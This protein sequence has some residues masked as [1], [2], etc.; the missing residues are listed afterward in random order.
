MR[1][2]DWTIIDTL[3]RY[4]SITKA[5]EIL[6][7]SQ[8]TLT[9]RIQAIE[10]DLGVTL[11][12]RS[13]RGIVFTQAGEY[14]AVQAKKIMELVNET[15]EQFSA[16]APV[17]EKLRICAPRSIQMY[18]LPRLLA[19][20]SRQYPQIQVEI[21]SGLSS[22]II[23]IMEQDDGDVGFVKGKHATSLE[24][25]PLYSSRLYVVNKG[26][27]D[28]DSLPEMEQ[29]SFI[30]DSSIEKAI[31]DWWREHFKRPPRIRMR[32][33]SGEACMAMIR[34]GLGYGIFSDRNYFRA[35][36]EVESLP[37][38]NRDGS[39]FARK[40]YLVFSQ[41][42]QHNEVVRCFLEFIQKYSFQT[43]DLV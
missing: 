5:A 7:L 3:H 36:P 33:S 15:R 21:R 16:A 18:V 23:R 41:N 29:I 14:A 42:S 27:I 22:D 26:S 20:F 34:E 2:F 17:I 11:L 35:V 13:P 19:E 31:D 39:A 24:K 9:K 28:L 1:D 8:P 40:T 12:Y 6:F 25:I 37:L 32:V 10:D 4:G 30:Q 38:T 43:P